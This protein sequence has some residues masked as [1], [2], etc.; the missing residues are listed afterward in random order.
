MKIISLIFIACF[1]SAAANAQVKKI[2]GYV[3]QLNGGAMQD[4]NST[5]QKKGRKDVTSA[6]NGRYFL[7]AEVVKKKTVYFQQVW[8]KGNLFSFRPDTIR[9]IPFIL[10]SSN[11]GELIN[12]DTLIKSS[13]QQIIQLK[14][15]VKKNTVVV[16]S[17]IKKLVA[18]NDVV[19]IFRYNGKISTISL[20]KLTAISP[21]FTQ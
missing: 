4:R 21:L 1:L 7:F 16:P 11:G 13:A 14:D 15:P 17:K 6:D 19:I 18:A 10:E 5:A 8:I 12:R 3:Q 9:R 20:K 2:Y